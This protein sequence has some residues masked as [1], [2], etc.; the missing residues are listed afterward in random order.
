MPQVRVYVSIPLPVGEVFD[1]LAD[2]RNLASWHSGVMAVRP[3]GPE[4]GDGY[5]YRFPGRR[6]ECRL[7]R[8]VYEPPVRVGFVGQRMWTP[9][10]TQVPRF[11]FRLWPWEAGCRVEVMVTCALSGAMLLLWPVVACGWRRDLPVDAQLLYEL[12]T[13]CGRPEESEAGAAAVAA[14]QAAGGGSAGRAPVEAVAGTT[15]IGP[16]ISAHP[17]FCPAGACWRV[18]G[19]WPARRFR[20]PRPARLTSSAPRLRRG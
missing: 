6:R 13:G 2:G 20:L 5:W 14:R 3:D 1:F 17:G 16:D 7:T 12:L 8:A 19:P 15:G 4:E 18:P 9:L 11:D 10:G